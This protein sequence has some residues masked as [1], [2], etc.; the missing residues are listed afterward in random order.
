MRTVFARARFAPMC[1]VTAAP[2]VDITTP[3]VDFRTLH[4]IRLKG[5]EL[6]EF[7][8]ITD[9][10]N[11]P[12]LPAVKKVLTKAGYTEPTPIQA[13]AW[14]IAIGK[15]DMISV[16]KTGSGKTCAYL[17]PAI[18]ELMLN[19]QNKSKEP[20]D[21][22]VF[23]LAPTRELCL[24]IME[25]INTYIGAVPEVKPAFSRDRRGRGR[26]RD[27][28]RR[29]P[30]G[31][32]STG[33]NAI[34][35][36]GGSD[37]NKQIR[38]LQRRDTQIVVGTPGRCND[39][40]EA[41][42]LSLRN[43]TYVVLDEADRMLDMGF[44]PQ[45]SQL[46]QETDRLRRQTLCFTA[47][48]PK[49]VQSLAMTYLKNPVQVNIGESD[50]LTANTSIDQNIRFVEERD[51][52]YE[53]ETLLGELKEKFLI[54]QELKLSEASNASAAPD[55]TTSFRGPNKFMTSRRTEP[56]VIIFSSRKASCDEVCFYLS[57]KGYQGVNSLHG[58]KSQGQRD[59]VMQAFR[60]GYCNYLVATDVAARGLDVSDIDVVVNLDMPQNIEDYVHRIGRTARGSNAHGAAYT[61]FTKNDY[62]L[63]RDLVNV[64]KRSKQEVPEELARY[65]RPDRPSYGHSRY[66]SSGGGGR[67]GRGSFSRGGGGGY[68]GGRHGGGGGGGFGS[69]QGSYEGD[70][71]FRRGPGSDM[72]SE[73]IGRAVQGGLGD[74]GGFRQGRS[75]RDRD[76]DRDRFSGSD[77]D[78]GFGG[79]GGSSYGG[80]RSGDYQ[81]GG[82][83]GS[84]KDA[85][86]FG[87]R[88]GGFGGGGQWGGS[89]RGSRRGMSSGGGSNFGRGG[90]AG[91]FE[92]A[93]PG[94]FPE[95]V[96]YFKKIDAQS[97]SK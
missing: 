14:P 76:G 25:Q 69:R 90:G 49:E 43:V 16:A 24:Q 46:L 47:T 21:V 59:R 53:L 40:M 10:N 57:G 61:F 11:S 31:P 23:V 29:G 74:S 45:I 88:D 30:E 66:G 19:S 63:G 27:R 36:Y 18:H 78:R 64:M 42:A 81:G 34:A 35:L 48:W 15:R 96:S 26:D 91:E 1:T 37:R 8:P 9:F 4:H 56:K 50:L 97:D 70:Q 85:G 84:F 5:M 22:S 55:A 62:K 52:Y 38:T 73:H 58:D 65:D 95:G 72:S 12:F 51:K 94:D 54:D 2:T 32:S 83:G 39:L 82:R 77:R 68:G 67:G 80:S 87:H 92:Y 7:M 44:E 60:K 17:L 13:Q 6:D 28:D 86:K 71:S 33:L 93:Q 41:G 89:G 20:C 75:H 79:R 3:P